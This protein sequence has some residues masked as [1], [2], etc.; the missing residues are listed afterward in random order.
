[1][2]TILGVLDNFFPRVQD[3]DFTT[4][5]GTDLY[6]LG[7]EVRRF[8]AAYEPPAPHP[9][10]YTIYLGGWPSANFW[11]STPGELVMSSLLYA[12]QVLAKDP[13]SD[14]FCYD[15]VEKLYSSRWGIYSHDGS[16]NIAGTR[17]YLREVV[18]RLLELRPLIEA[19]MLVL[20][21]SRPFLAQHRKAI[22]QQRDTL[23][24]AVVPDPLQFTRQF[25]PS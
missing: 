20:V 13:I 8:A 9:D 14:W 4:I 17:R 19:E 6:R 2:V 24:P 3:V 7:E 23:L 18:P 12:G 16:L 10:T 5:P 22:Y 15:D 25:R 1:M 21:P 11:Y